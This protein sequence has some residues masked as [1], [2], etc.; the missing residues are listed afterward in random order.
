MIITVFTLAIFYCFFSLMRAQREFA[1]LRHVHRRLDSMRDA[2]WPGKLMPNSLPHSLVQERMTLYFEQVKQGAAPDGES[3]SDKVYNGL[4]MRT[5]VSRYLAGLLVFLGLLGTFIGLLMSLGSIK[6]LI[7][8]LP[9]GGSENAGP[10]FFDAL[11]TGLAAPLGG[12]GTA[13]STSVFG[14]SGSLIL[15]FLH[16][17]L[18][19]AQG[20]FISQLETFDSAFLKP[21]Y[22]AHLGS[23]GFTSAGAGS[24]SA[25]YLDAAQRAMGRNIDQLMTLMEKAEKL[26]V[27]YREALGV[28]GR[29]I[30]VINTA[31]TRLGSNQ[32]L[33]REG[34]TNLVELTYGMS[35][36]QRL[37][38][39]ETQKMHETLG[40]LNALVKESTD[41]HGD[42][43]D[44]LVRALRREMG[45]LGALV[46][47]KT[48]RS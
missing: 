42:K 35:D 36:N 46:V 37:F 9:T 22:R 14:L 48:G 30:E 19:S 7:M 38:L 17:Q 15:G 20:R 21:A 28:I 41:A 10:E 40:R 1:A 44:D 33:I 29:E 18:S 43:M 5:S 47:D 25:D 39:A 31:V 3:H 6:D 34:T 27:N 45:T 13:F 8:N 4:S 26:Q 11:K 24:G 23:R 32:D 2:D 16:I 12:M